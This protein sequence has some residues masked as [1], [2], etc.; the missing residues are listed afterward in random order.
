VSSLVAVTLS[1]DY[2]G[3]GAIDAA[4]YTV[5]RDS[6][7]QVGAGLAADGDRDGEI[8]SLDYNVWK[9]H[10]GEPFGSGSA[11]LTPVILTPEPHTLLLLM[12]VLASNVAVAR[13]RERAWRSMNRESAWLMR[14][15][16][17]TIDCA[18][19]ALAGTVRDPQVH[20]Q[21]NPGDPSNASAMDFL[22]AD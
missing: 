15:G 9:T 18:S 13:N 8:T 1:G 22:S 14:T 4:D 6:L 17:A 20:S 2:N 3:D 5:W 16:A 11:S 10:F 7:G 19:I 21:C 12:C